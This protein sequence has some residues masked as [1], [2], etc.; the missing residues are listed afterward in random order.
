MADWNVHLVVLKIY[1]SQIV[2]ETYYFHRIHL[3]SQGSHKV[4]DQTHT[5]IGVVYKLASGILISFYIIYV[6]INQ[7]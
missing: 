7:R 5:T 6:I 3:R 4:Q 1:Y 2:A